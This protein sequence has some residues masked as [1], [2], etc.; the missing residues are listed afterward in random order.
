MNTKI[1][2]TLLASLAL[3]GV[4]MPSASVFAVDYQMD[5]TGGTEL[6]N[7]VELNPSLIDS[8][9]PLI[10][11]NMTS[12]ETSSSNRWQNG[13]IP[14]GE[15]CYP[16]RYFKVSDSE[17]SS[18]TRELSATFYNDKYATDIQFANITLSH[19]AGDNK[20]YAI[21]L[22]EYDGYLETG[23]LVY[24]DKDC[25]IP[26]D[27][28]KALTLAEEEKIFIETKLSVRYQNSTKPLI[29]NGLYFGLTDIDASQSYKILNTDNML[30]AANMFTKS[31]EG[32]QPDSSVTPLRNMFNADEHYI[33]SQYD[34]AQNPTSIS[35]PSTANIYVKLSE[36]TQ[37]EGLKMVF[38]FANTAGSG[39]EYYAKQF[40]VSYESDEHG[41]ILGIE[42]ESVIGGENP[43]GTEQVPE[44]GYINK[45]WVADVD[46]ELSDG[47]KIKAGDPLTDAQILDVVVDQDIV[48]TALH[49]TEETPAPAVPETGMSTKI[50]DAATIATVSV[51]GVLFLALMVRALPR[52]TRKKVNFE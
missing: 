41:E 14:S 1:K 39:V 26:V 27:D 11:I 33:Y 35:L 29:S 52:I 6:Q 51:F 50:T 8:L 36:D 48:F 4:A 19:P 25:S 17:T 24:S 47:T 3:F 28:I 7:S 42:N 23:W 45:N 49:V 18:Q 9:S 38:G 16:Y 46:V 5:Y 2:K 13:Y 44:E 20:Y 10:Q 22:T 21:G 34:I 15:F 31:T 32:L 12:L 43:S 30:N 37:Q 40:K